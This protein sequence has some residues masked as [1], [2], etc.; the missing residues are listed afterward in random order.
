MPVRPEVLCFGAEPVLNRTRRLILQSV[1]DV[2]VASTLAELASWLQERHFQ[3]V[4]LCQTLSL[5]GARSALELVHTL[6]PGARILG[7]DDGHPRLYLR[8]PHREVHLEGPIDL[9]SKVASMAGIRLPESVPSQVAW[10]TR[11]P[12]PRAE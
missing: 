7:L 4:I 3:V 2:C 1:F 11:K 8:P 12:R 10:T 6:R 9:L 5:D